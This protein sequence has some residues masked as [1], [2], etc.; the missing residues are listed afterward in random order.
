MLSF[1]LHTIC[2][3]RI[4]KRSNIQPIVKVKNQHYCR[5]N[6]LSDYIEKL[7]NDVHYVNLLES[8]PDEYSCKHIATIHCVLIICIL[9]F[10]F[11]DG[12]TKKD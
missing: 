12:N 9:I 11:V 7:T 8:Q 1:R 6:V 2:P 3:I 5:T 4:I 10:M